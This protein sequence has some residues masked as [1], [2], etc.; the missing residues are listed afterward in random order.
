LF[1]RNIDSRKPLMAHE[2][3]AKAANSILMLRVDDCLQRFHTARVKRDEGEPHGVPRVNDSR[4]LNGIFWSLRSGAS[5]SGS[6]TRSSKVGGSRRA[7]T[8]SM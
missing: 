4:V 3:F 7:I 5:S 1:S 8:S 2:G 6:S